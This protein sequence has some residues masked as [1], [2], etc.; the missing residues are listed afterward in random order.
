MQFRGFLL[1][2]VTCHNPYISDFY[3]FVFSEYESTI[4]LAL[5]LP[6]TRPSGPE[7]RWAGQC[8]IDVL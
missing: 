7:R 2:L 1:P 3:L 5:A 4:S 8:P 6:G